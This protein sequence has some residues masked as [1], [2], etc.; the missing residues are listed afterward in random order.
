MSVRGQG[1]YAEDDGFATTAP[2]GSFPRGKSRYGLFDVVG[3]VWEWTS[4]WEGKYT[5]APATDPHGP[6]TGERRV[7]RGGAFNGLLPSWVRPSQRYSDLPKTH[8]H[9]YGFRCAQ[10]L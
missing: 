6:A 4:D 2:V 9:A 10:S 5:A 3:N 7:V 1:M 8:S